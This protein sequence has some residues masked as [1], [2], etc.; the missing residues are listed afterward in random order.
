MASENQFKLILSKEA[1][2]DI[3]ELYSFYESIRPGFG[4]VFMTSIEECLLE[5]EIN[6]SRWQFVYGKE[7]RIRRASLQKPPV[8]VLYEIVESQIFIATVK[9]T[10]SDWQ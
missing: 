8:V 10:R 6:P 4:D 1:S 5:I 9:D 3:F 2:D 7:E